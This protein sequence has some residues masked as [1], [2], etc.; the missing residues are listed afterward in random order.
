VIKVCTHTA[1]FHAD[2]VFALAII[3]AILGKQHIQIVRSRDPKVWEGCQ[4]LVDV[5]EEYD[6]EK[7]RFDHHHDKVLPASCCLVWHYYGMEYLRR[8]NLPDDFATILQV[9]K[10]LLQ[11]ISEL[12]TQ[13]ST[14]MHE[15][16]ENGYLTGHISTVI[17]AFNALP[18]DGLEKAIQTADTILRAVCHQVAER[19]KHLEVI[20]QGKSMG[21]YLVMEESIPWHDFLDDLDHHYLV[22]PNMDH[23]DWRVVSTNSRLRPLP[24]AEGPC[25]YFHPGQFVA[26]FSTRD[27]ALAYANLLT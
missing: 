4:L 2:D 10:R 24:K 1:P 13:Y 18:S 14:L 9:E 17:M 25:I 19:R 27:E 21:T 12:D 3:Q 16:P 5:G 7:G 6:P 22:Y 15:K 20:R 11:R 8:L 26:V 23:T